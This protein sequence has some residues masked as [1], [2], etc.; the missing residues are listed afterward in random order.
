MVSP[1]SSLSQVSVTARTS[2]PVTVRWWE[3]TYLLLTRDLALTKQQ[4][5]NFLAALLI[6]TDLPLL[7][8][9]REGNTA[10]M[11]SD[12]TII[13]D[14]SESRVGHREEKRRENKVCFEYRRRGLG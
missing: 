7:Q 11:P 3:M 4:Y 5:R 13:K 1:F 14:L 9:R 12:L 10:G 6:F 8:P 2:R